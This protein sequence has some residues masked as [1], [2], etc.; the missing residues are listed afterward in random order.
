MYCIDRLCDIFF[1]KPKP[2]PQIY[3]FYVNHRGSVWFWQFFLSRLMS[4]WEPCVFIWRPHW[5]HWNFKERRVLMSQLNKLRSP[6]PPTIIGVWERITVVAQW[7]K[8]LN[9]SSDVLQLLSYKQPTVLS[10]HVDVAVVLNVHGLANCTKLQYYSCNEH[11]N[12]SQNISIHIRKKIN[13]HEKFNWR[14]FLTF[15]NYH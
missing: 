7:W 3:L 12:I 15:F 1:Y 10:S 2:R 8:I 11:P 13:L 14:F 6:S 4:L 5:W 9:H